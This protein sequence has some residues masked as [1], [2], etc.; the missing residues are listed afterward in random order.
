MHYLHCILVRFEDAE[1][2]QFRKAPVET[3]VEKARD[4]ALEATDY[5]EGRVFDWRLEDAGRWAD[6]YPRKGV[7]LGLAERE[8]FL[9]LLKEWK[10]MPLRDALDN[11]KWARGRKWNWRTPEELEPDG[12]KVFPHPGNGDNGR[13]WSAIPVPQETLVLGEKLLRELWENPLWGYS[14]V[15]AVSLADAQYFPES[16]FYSVPDYSPKISEEVLQEAR[17]HPQRFALV[18]LDYHY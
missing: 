18:F 5:Y 14:I 1:S 12:A 3:L 8:K 2:E 17:E 6:Q 13:Y 16:Q 7:V 4:A 10:D 9:Q 11:L 15:L